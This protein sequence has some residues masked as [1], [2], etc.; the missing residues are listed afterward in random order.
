MSL[1]IEPAWHRA[2]KMATAREG[3]KMTSV[4]L[5]F[6]KDYVR[7]HMPEAVPPERGKK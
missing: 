2:F 6:I 4:I 1:V 3:K 7:T 5:Q